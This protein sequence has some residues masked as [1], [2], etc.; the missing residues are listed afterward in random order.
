MSRREPSVPEPW[1][2]YAWAFLL[3]GLVGLACVGLFGPGLR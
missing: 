1:E 2:R 3:G